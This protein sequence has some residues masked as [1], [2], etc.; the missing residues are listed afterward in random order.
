M[1]PV[2][3]A[4]EPAAGERHRAP[5]S[6]D[7]AGAAIAADRPLDPTPLPGTAAAHGLRAL[8]GDP[9]RVAIVGATGYV[10]AELVRLLARHPN[11][12]I[13]GLVG[14]ERQGDPLGRHP[15]PPG[16]RGPP[17]LRRG[18]RRRR[19]RVPRPAPRCGRG[20]D[21]RVPRAGADGDR[22][23]A[24][25]PP[26]R[27]RGLP[28]LVPLRPPPPRAP[29]DRGLRPARAAPGRARPRRARSRTRS[30]ARPAAT[31]RRRSWRS[32][33]WPGPASSRTSSWT[34]RAASRAPAASPRPTSSSARSTR[35]SR[36]TGSSPT[37][38]SARSS[39]SWARSA[40]GWPPTPASAASTSSPT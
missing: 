1:P 32:P 16:D 27:P 8:D 9:V 40:A 23:R 6:A 14:R 25:L 34:P 17:G 20:A 3:R 15:S 10:G 39:R 5:V 36:R 26:P 37:A 22:P 7:S 18:P 35:A 30:S 21:R 11:V 13:V 4:F 33:R 28:A 19:G 2:L 31:R 12:A 38:T 24:R 29:R